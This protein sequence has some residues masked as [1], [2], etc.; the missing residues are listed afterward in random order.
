MRF[1]PIY[2]DFLFSGRLETFFWIFEC[3]QR[4]PLLIEIGKEIAFFNLHD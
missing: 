4:I 3:S 2:M 1:S